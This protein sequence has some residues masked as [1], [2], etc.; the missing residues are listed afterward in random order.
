[1]A[2]RASVCRS[3]APP[4]PEF[5]DPR[6]VLPQVEHEGAI[7]EP[8]QEESIARN[9]WGGDVDDHPRRR[10]GILPIDRAGGRIQADHVI[11][12]PADQH[13]PAGLPDDDRG[14]IG[15][16]IVQGPPALDAGLLVQ[17]HQ[18][19]PLGAE[20]DNHQLAIDQ[21]RRGNA[22]DRHAD[23][24]VHPGCFFQSSFPVAASRQCRCPMVP[25]A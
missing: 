9:D 7:V 21:R 5:F 10:E 16:L 18:A 17:G 25:K 12:R 8:R 6:L 24:V 3:L 19:R 23:L 14:R 13:A 1:M 2:C 22:P 20:L 15:R 11:A 4:S